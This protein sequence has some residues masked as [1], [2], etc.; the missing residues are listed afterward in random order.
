MNGSLNSL[1]AAATN[2]GVEGDDATFASL[3]SPARF[4]N[5]TQ[6]LVQDFLGI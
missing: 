3:T 2:I 6:I 1:A 4:G 5:Y